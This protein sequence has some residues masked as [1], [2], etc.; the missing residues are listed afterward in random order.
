MT[1]RVVH[2]EVVGPDGTALKQ[3]Y[4]GVFGWQI[5]S[6]NPMDYGSVA[7]P[8]EGPG[9]GG[10]I[11]AAGEDGGH[12]A[13]FYVAVDD[14]QGTLDAAV[15]AGGSVVMGVTEIPGVVTLA[16]FT[17]PAGNLIGLI[18]AEPPS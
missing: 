10:G 5:D 7:T 6:G 11:S 1:N 9:I 3:F 18:K 2:F 8:E 16:Q 15:A 17:D 12:Y 4:A 13:T 14:P